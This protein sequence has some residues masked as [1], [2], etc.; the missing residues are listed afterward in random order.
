MI[1]RTVNLYKNAYSGLTQKIWLLSV[2]MLINRAGTMVLAFMTLYI[3]HLG[4][5]IKQGGIVVAIYGLGSVVVLC[6]V[7]GLG[8][9]RLKQDTLPAIKNLR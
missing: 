8:F 3:N 4:F 7:A 1:T 2:V 5:T 9:Y 6:I